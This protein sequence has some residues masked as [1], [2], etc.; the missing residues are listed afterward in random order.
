MKIEALTEYFQ[1][2]SSVVL[3]FLFGSRAKGRE[4]EVSD[5]DIGVYFTPIEYLETETERE[6]PDKRRIWSDLVDL[7]ETDDVDLAV[8]NRARPSLVY[9]V[10]RTGSPLTIRDR[11]LYLDLLCKVSYEAVDWWD[12]VSDF[13]R[14]SEK[15][16]SLPPEEKEC[17]KATANENREFYS[18][19]RALVSEV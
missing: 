8:L 4:G 5:W 6:Y 10:L 13:Y 18:G 9:N 2:E 7:L 14:I 12:F 11:R 16:K 17:C 1:K 3:A 19:V 15:A